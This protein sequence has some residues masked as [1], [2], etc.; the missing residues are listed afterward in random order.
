LEKTDSTEGLTFTVLGNM[1]PAIHQPAWYRYIGAI[2][3]KELEIASQ[4]EVVVLRHVAQFKC[5]DFQVLCDS[6]RWQLHFSAN[7]DES[8]PR[9]T[10]IAEKVFDV[11]LKHTPATGVT[12]Q[13]H[14]HIG[15]TGG[16]D[17]ASRLGRLLSRPFHLTGIGETG[18]QAAFLS[19][20]GGETLQ[21]DVQPSVLDKSRVY[22]GAVLHCKF[23]GPSS[24]EGPF[25]EVPIAGYMTERI[26]RL[27]D[28]LKAWSETIRSAVEGAS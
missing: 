25:S 17:V 7:I 4:G 23:E 8:I 15:L 10:A 3:D 26:P 12:L 5:G 18:A 27:L 6:D 28:R 1:N 9:A 14:N 16:P 24:T 19:R 2:S 20:V 11:S 22:V 21:L 13:F